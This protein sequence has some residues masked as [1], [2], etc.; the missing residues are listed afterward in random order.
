MPVYR[1]NALE[2]P[3][4][5]AFLELMPKDIIIRWLKTS[6]IGQQALDRLERRLNMPRKDK[7]CIRTE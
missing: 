7:P 3:R 2:F 6:W 5:I 4:A 1:D